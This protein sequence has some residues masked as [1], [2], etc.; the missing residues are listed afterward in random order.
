[1]PEPLCLV[2][3]LPQLSLLTVHMNDGRMYHYECMIM[4]LA[5]RKACEQPR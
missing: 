3:G 1:M 5:R 4:E 2:C